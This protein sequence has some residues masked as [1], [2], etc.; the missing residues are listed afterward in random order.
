MGRNATGIRRV[1]HVNHVRANTTKK[2]EDKEIEQPI[3]RGWVSVS[4][5]KGTRVRA[6]GGETK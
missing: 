3:K 6:E 2:G 5:R 1:K 4:Q